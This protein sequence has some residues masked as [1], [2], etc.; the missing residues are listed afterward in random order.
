MCQVSCLCSREHDWGLLP[1]SWGSA[2]G[3]LPQYLSHLSQWR[4]LQY[5]FRQWSM[6]V[7]ESAVSTHVAGKAPRQIGCRE[8]AWAE[9]DQVMQAHVGELKRCLHEG[10]FCICLLPSCLACFSWPGLLTNSPSCKDRGFAQECVAQIKFTCWSFHESIGTE[11]VCYWLNSSDCV[12]V[13]RWTTG[14]ISMAILWL[15][16]HATFSHASDLHSTSFY[17]ATVIFGRIESRWGDVGRRSW[18]IWGHLSNFWLWTSRCLQ[19]WI[20]DVSSCVNVE[21]VVATGEGRGHNDPR[22]SRKFVT[23]LGVHIRTRRSV[24]KY[25][26]I[27]ALGIY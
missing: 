16:S 8:V 1:H 20:K 24:T 2:A 14:E 18:G 13:I 19:L 3:L 27:W 11:V 15:L 5:I 23:C 25:D 17:N 7:N 9:G 26:Q 22:R 6:Q 12:R 4:Q 10:I 21:C